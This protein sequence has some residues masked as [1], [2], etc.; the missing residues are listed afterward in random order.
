MARWVFEVHNEGEIIV[1]TVNGETFR[2]KI[3]DAER[4]QS[5]LLDLPWQ[6]RDAI[7]WAQGINPRSGDPA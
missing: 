5:R 1:L 4:L 3:E 2:L 6:I 7:C